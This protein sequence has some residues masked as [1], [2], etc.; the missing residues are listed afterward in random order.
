VHAIY[1]GHG[2][3]ISNGAAAIAIYIG[4]RQTREK[5]ILE[6]LKNARKSQSSSASSP[7]AQTAAAAGEMTADEIVTAV[8]GT[9]ASE[10][11]RT[12][13]ANNVVLHLQKLLKERM[14]APRSETST[15]IDQNILLASAKWRLL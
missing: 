11:L 8:Y 2:P 4:H 7:T 12:G 10:Q 1:P 14:V 3:V 5:Q 9:L 13:A 15:S 6:V